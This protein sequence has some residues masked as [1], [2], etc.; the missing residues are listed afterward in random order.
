MRLERMKRSQVVAVCSL[1]FQRDKHVI[2][3]YV[4]GSQTKSGHVIRVRRFGCK[5]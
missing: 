4:L 2:I 3:P 1:L 5:Y